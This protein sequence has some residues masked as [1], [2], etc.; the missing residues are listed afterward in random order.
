[1]AE[2]KMCSMDPEAEQSYIQKLGIVENLQEDVNILRGKTLLKRHINLH[3]Y[4]Y[5][6]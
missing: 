1:M 6:I 4:T 3:C 5:L 2:I